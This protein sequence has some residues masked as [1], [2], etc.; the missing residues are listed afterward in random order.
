MKMELYVVKNHNAV[1]ARDCTTNIVT[2]I[3]PIKSIQETTQIKPLTLT[4][5]IKPIL[6][7][8]WSSE[9]LTEFLYSGK[10]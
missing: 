10:N 4:T 8:S 7:I 2:N 1:G 9:S 5:P 6:N 3:E